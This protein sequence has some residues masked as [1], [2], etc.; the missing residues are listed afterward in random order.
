MSKAFLMKDFKVGKFLQGENPQ[1]PSGHLYKG[2]T[3]VA[4]LQIGCVFHGDERFK[5]TAIL[6]CNDTKVTEGK[7]FYLP[8]YDESMLTGVM[9]HIFDTRDAASRAF[10]INASDG[11]IDWDALRTA[12]QY[13]TEHPHIIQP[14]NNP[15][16][17]NESQIDV[18][19]ALTHSAVLAIIDSQPTWSTEDAKTFLAAVGEAYPQVDAKTEHGRMLAAISDALDAMGAK[20][21]GVN[22]GAILQ[23]YTARITSPLEQARWDFSHFSDAA[24]LMLRTQW[25]GYYDIAQRQKYTPEVAATIATLQTVQGGMDETRNTERG[26][27]SLSDFDMKRCAAMCDAAAQ[28]ALEQGVSQ[29]E[30]GAIRNHHFANYDC[31]YTHDPVGTTKFMAS[32]AYEECMPEKLEVFD[33][34]QMCFD[35]QRAMTVDERLEATIQ[36]MNQRMVEKHGMAAESLP[37]IESVKQAMDQWTKQSISPGTYL[38]LRIGPLPQTMV[39]QCQMLYLRQVVCEGALHDINNAATCAA[40][41]HKVATTLSMEVAP[42]SPAHNALEQIRATTAQEMQSLHDQPSTEDRDTR[43]DIGDDTVG[44]DAI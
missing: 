27:F 34:F 23:D 32:Y 37:T 18:P 38:A 24:A 7:D 28:K 15:N 42:G 26:A 29:Y 12:V 19:M 21:E 1:F 3:T 25:N 39:E 36:A 5:G 9:L 44:D 40:A 20:G 30:V 11:K 14:V 43:D 17:V 6:L 22:V 41:L 8:R 4:G 16:G 10:T 35:G 13:Y 2:T 33:V 31:V